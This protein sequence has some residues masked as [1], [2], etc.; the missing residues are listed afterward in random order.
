MER[1]GGGLGATYFGPCWCSQCV[2]IC[3]SECFFMVPNGVLV[4]C[5][6][7]CVQIADVTLYFLSFA[8]S[9][10]SSK[11]YIDWIK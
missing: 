7:S 10:N 6:P 11:V 1:E 8:Q 5:F 2:Y 3:F 4:M 9:S